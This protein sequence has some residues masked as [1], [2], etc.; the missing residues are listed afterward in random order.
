MN[1]QPFNQTLSTI[2]AWTLRTSLEAT[3]LIALV[4]LVQ[5]VFRK[6]LPVKWRYLLSLLILVRL[7]VPGLPASHFSIFNLKDRFSTSNPAHQ[8]ASATLPET[9]PVIPAS[10][11]FSKPSVPNADGA[12]SFNWNSL[13]RNVWLL[14]C[15]AF[16]LVVLRQHF[17]LSR[18]AR[19]QTELLDEPVLTLLNN[20]R[21]L[22]GVRRPIRIIN[23]PHLHTPAVFGLWKPCLLIPAGM[24][25]R[26]NQA[27]LRLVFLHEL[28]HVRRGDVLLNWLIILMRS[29]H[30]FNPFV[31]LAMKRLRS[32]Q[33]LVC[34]AQVLDHL[35]AADRRLYGH[36]LLKLLTHYSA[37]RLC[38]SLVPFITNTK[39]IQRRIT[40][41]TQYK[42][43]SRIALAGSLAL[44]F[45]LGLI[46]F[47]RAAEESTAPSPN[48]AKPATKSSVQSKLDGEREALKKGMAILQQELKL[49]DEK[50]LAAEQEL[51]QL[52]VHLQV[53]R[54]VA[55]GAGASPEDAMTTQ[56]YGSLRIDA[57]G[58][59]VKQDALLKQLKKLDHE[60]LLQALPTACPDLGLVSLLT[61]LD[62]TQARLAG[63]R[64]SYGNEHPKV[65][66]AVAVEA[67]QKQ[68]INDRAAGILTGMEARLAS[69]KAVMD[70]SADKLKTARD[71]DLEAERKYRPYL[72]QKAELDRLTRF[73]DVLALRL[74]QERINHE[75]PES[76]Q[77]R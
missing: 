7:V 43:T 29:L 31:W 24:L 63:L 21:D 36:T 3:V 42:S 75:F 30:W 1:F 35:A 60:Q 6:F 19:K 77:A 14:G 38:P 33:E 46:T 12:R 41:I 64:Q 56:H 73:R 55:Q 34:D 25:T 48:Q 70:N 23:A 53:P 39:I 74:A 76:K 57:E 71:E 47:T 37:A 20:C 44:L 28:V 9:T 40:M 17:K 13:A 16:L 2:F 68:K 15:A 10:A 45:L 65:V 66:E 18:W 22:L 50:V 67:A 69:Y 61:E 62:K 26:L 52:R 58:E 32:D 54:S 5:C 72:Q 27:E 8:I 11:P 51:D 59:Y 4:L 49:S